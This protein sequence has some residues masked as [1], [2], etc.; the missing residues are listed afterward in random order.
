MNSLVVY[1]HAT[2]KSGSRLIFK[3]LSIYKNILQKHKNTWLKTKQYIC[4]KL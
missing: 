4:G 2:D 3:I 1:K